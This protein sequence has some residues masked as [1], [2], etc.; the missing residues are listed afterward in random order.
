MGS[1]LSQS[2]NLRIP[3]LQQCWI[4]N[5]LHLAGINTALPQ[6]QA[7]SLT[8]YAMV[9]TPTYF[10]KNVLPFL[11]C[12]GPPPF[13]SS[14]HLHTLLAYSLYLSM[15][16]TTNTEEFVFVLQ[17]CNLIICTF[18]YLIFLIISYWN[19]Y[20][21]SGRTLTDFLNGLHSITSYYV[22]W[23]SCPFSPLLAALYFVSRLL[24][25]YFVFIYST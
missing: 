23:F 4:L 15:Y 3:Q 19:P 24:F 17:K 13:F 10:F 5:P 16:I 2:C 9:G 18:L 21:S 11:F 8:H 25:V 22:P 7:G 6:R 14:L 1:N 20:K 12:L